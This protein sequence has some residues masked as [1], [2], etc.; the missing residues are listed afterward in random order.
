MNK[1]LLLLGIILLLTTVRKG[2]AQTDMLSLKEKGIG[3]QHYSKGSYM[4]CLLENGVWVTGYI[5]KMQNDSITFKPFHL[6]Q[7]VN[8]WGTIS[9]DTQWLAIFKFHYAQ[10][11]GFPKRKDEGFIYLKNGALLRGGAI[12]YT[13]VNLISRQ[14]EAFNGRNLI[15]LGIAATAFA[16]GKILKKQYSPYYRIGKKYTLK[17]TEL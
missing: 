11:T 14:R 16:V 3:I 12:L 13:A 10:I 7:F 8:Q 15:N 9:L 5:L 6:V 4:K 2:F 1:F 17:Y